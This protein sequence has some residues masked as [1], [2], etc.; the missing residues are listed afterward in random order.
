MVS[1]HEPRQPGVTITNAGDGKK[2]L[3]ESVVLLFRKPLNLRLFCRIAWQPCFMRWLIAK[4]GGNGRA[5][6]WRT[7]VVVGGVEQVRLGNE[8]EER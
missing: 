7:A 5:L 3:V 6:Q 1:R 8:P 2:L 4:N